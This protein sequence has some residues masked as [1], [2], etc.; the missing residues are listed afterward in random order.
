MS[1]QN[2]APISHSWNQQ[3]SQLTSANGFSN[4]NTTGNFNINN[5]NN[6]TNNNQN[7]NGISQPLSSHSYSPTF[8][9]TLDSKFK[10][11]LHWDPVFLWKFKPAGSFSFPLPTG[12][13]FFFASGLI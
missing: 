3:R 9:L 7:G 2:G 5:N 10:F 1:P 13:L 12:L 6:N 4:Q 11:P 8:W